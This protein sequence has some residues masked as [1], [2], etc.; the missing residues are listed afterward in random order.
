MK[1]ATFVLAA[2]CAAVLLVVPMSDVEAQYSDAWVHAH[3][4]SAMKGARFEVPVVDTKLLSWKVEDAWYEAHRDPNELGDE[5][6]QFRCSIAAQCPEKLWP[7][8]TNQMQI[9]IPVDGNY[10]NFDPANKMYYDDPRRKW[11]NSSFSGSVSQVR[12]IRCIEGGYLR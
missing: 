7:T 4:T 1:L 6:V 10:Y 8:G 5:W 12:K 2:V 9:W 11:V 3:C